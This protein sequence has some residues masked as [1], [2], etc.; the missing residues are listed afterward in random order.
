M[1]NRCGLAAEMT[2]L[3]KK[4]VS[5]PSVNS[6]GY[7]E[8]DMAAFIEEYLRSFPY[9]R[10]HPD[11]VI[12]QPL[13]NDPHER[14][15]VFALIVGEKTERAETIL[16]HGHIDTVGVEDYGAL[17]E[18]AFD[19][20]ALAERLAQLDL[21][22]DVQSDL[23]S[24]DWLFGRGAGDMK[25]GDAVFL[26]LANYLSAC[27]AEFGGNLLLSFNPVEENSHTGILEALD[28]LERL[29]KERGLRYLFAV[30]N[31]YFCPQYP[32]DTT[33]YL[34][35]GAVGKLLPCFYIQGRE[36]HVGQCFEGFDAAL[37]AAELARIVGLNC[38]F[39]DGYRDEFTPPPSVLKM[40]DLKESYNVQTPCA[41]FIYFNYFVHNASIGDITAKLKA[42]A[43][44]ALENVERHRNG[45][46]VRYCELTKTGCSPLHFEK[47]VLLYS[48]LFSLA[49]H[50]YG[51]GL[52]ERTDGIARR[53]LNSGADLREIP[54]AVV[55]E[56]CR[57]AKISDPTA[58]LF[59][60]APYCPHNT[61]H[62]EDPAE[63]PFYEKLTQTVREFGESSGETFRVMQFFQS[64]SDSS[65]LSIDDDDASVAELLVNFPAQKLLYPLPLEQIRRLNIPA[66]DY[67]CCCRDAHKW[68]ERLYL[69][70]SFGVLPELLLHTFRN[71]L[72]F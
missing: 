60:A 29:K 16:L 34:Y 39:C 70:Y 61:V 27:T 25:G 50:E 72:Y 38:D 66:V 54:L 10:A 4:L 2:A 43:A 44:Q 12:V 42:A 55:R 47:R 17:S 28:V 35:T 64:L 15:N 6:Q 24:G 21:P 69:P 56:L 33:R 32:G 48:E 20:D 58:V 26:V 63:A 7:G 23:A 37:A 46:Y 5:I 65:Y 41:S 36:T 8:R 31:D 18:Y 67:G 1:I 22:E 14:R 71:F 3:T 30:N 9:F 53:L 51:P 13:R 40:K 57:I 59:F 52:A 19:C 49:E 11:Q 62:P 68:T 45:Q